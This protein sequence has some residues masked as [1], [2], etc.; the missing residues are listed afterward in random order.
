VHV[1]LPTTYPT[2]PRTDLSIATAAF[3]HTPSET[4]ASWLLLGLLWRTL[5]HATTAAESEVDRAED[6]RRSAGGSGPRL[7]HA[8][9]CVCA[10]LWL[11]A[12]AVGWSDESGPSRNVLVGQLAYDGV[13]WLMLAW[14]LQ[15]PAGCG[16]PEE[17]D[18]CCVGYST[19]RGTHQSA[20]D[21]K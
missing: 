7:P 15:P 3:F 1:S 4:A 12:T 2:Y 9:L 19:S 6:E 13:L 14:L 11:V 20:A 17:T 18:S 21:W 8:R 10:A 5:P 16:A